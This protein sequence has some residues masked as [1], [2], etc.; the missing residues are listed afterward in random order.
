MSDLIQSVKTKQKEIQN[1]QTESTRAAGKHEQL[2]KQLSENFQVS[3]KEEAKK[4]LEEYENV[5]NEN[6]KILGEMDTELEQII[7]NAKSGTKTGAGTKT[8]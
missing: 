1:L 5:R 8:S 3:T 6:V 2:L 4:L 7:T